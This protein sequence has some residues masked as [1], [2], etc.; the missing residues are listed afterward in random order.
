MTEEINSKLVKLAKK[1]SDRFNISFEDA[2]H[3]DV[4]KADQNTRAL[5]VVVGRIKAIR[6]NRFKPTSPVFGFSRFFGEYNF[7]RDIYDD[8]CEIENLYSN[9]FD[10][11]KN[12]TRSQ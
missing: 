11:L 9:Y 6:E 2:E 5:A 10:K 1:I 12:D 8:A 3:A 4:A 7:D